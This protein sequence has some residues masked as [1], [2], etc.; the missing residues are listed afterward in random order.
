VIRY[1]SLPAPVPGRGAGRAPL[2]HLPAGVA[3]ADAVTPL[4]PAATAYLA[5]STHGDLRAGEV[6]LVS[7]AA[8]NVGSAMVTMAAEAGAHVVAT[9]GAA[10]VDY[11]KALGAAEV[12]DYRGA[13]PSRTDVDLYVDT[14]GHNDLAGALATLAERG[15]L[16]VLAGLR[17]RPELP[18]AARAVNRLMAQGRLRTRRTEA[19]PLSETA[20]VHDRHESGDLHGRHVILQVAG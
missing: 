15:R 5:L 18:A 10:D 12:L 13:A 6:V 4:H 17:T 11:C 2:Y 7:G 8:G 14:S 19:L 20:R 1:G 9:A 16:V 3:P